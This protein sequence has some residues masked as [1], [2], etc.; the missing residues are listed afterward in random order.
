MRHEDA[1]LALW[2]ASDQAARERSN[3]CAE[4]AA[5]ELA[6]M[7]ASGR[8]LRQRAGAAF[9]TLG[10][11]IGGD[12]PAAPPVRRTPLRRLAGQGS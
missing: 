2:L 4:L 9:I 7:P 3:P 6:A 8:S 1:G 12:A 5:A 11:R 10:Q